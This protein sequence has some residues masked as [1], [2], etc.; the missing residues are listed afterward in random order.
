MHS[1]A[2]LLHVSASVQLLVITAAGSAENGS[3]HVN[4]AIA[5]T[6]Q[7]YPSSEIAEHVTLIRVAFDGIGLPHAEYIQNSIACVITWLS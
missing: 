5:P 1:G 7:R 3:V 6:E 4:V 2:V